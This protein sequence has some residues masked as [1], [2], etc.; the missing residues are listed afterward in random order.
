S[1]PTTRSRWPGDWMCGRLRNGHPAIKFKMAC[2]NLLPID[3]RCADAKHK[4]AILTAGGLAPC[5]SS[6]TAELIGRYT[7][8]APEA[9]IIGYFGGYAGLLQGKSLTVAPEIRTH[10]NI[11]HAHGGSPIGNSRV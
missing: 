2:T 4:A 6:V 9:G 10:A 8:L 11:L 1:A 7:E 3:P 5:L